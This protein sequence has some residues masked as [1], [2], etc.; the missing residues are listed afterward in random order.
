MFRKRFTALVVTLL[1]LTMSAVPLSAA[2]PQE[3]FQYSHELF[4]EIRGLVEGNYVLPID[5]SETY[6]GAVEGYI[7]GMGDPHTKFYTPEEYK[8]FTEGI[9]GIYEGVGLAIGKTD[10]YI[11]VISPVPN[12]PGEEAGIKTGDK[13]IEINGESMI[14]VSLDYAA[15]LLRG[16][17]GTKVLLKLDRD[18]EVFSV[19]LERRE[20]ET[21]SVEYELHGPI[22]YM[23]I[24]S[25]SEHLPEDFDE[26]MEYFTENEIEG[27]I[28]DVRNNPGG[29]LGS[30]HHIVSKFLDGTVMRMLFRNGL[31]LPLVTAEMEER[32][33]M[34]LVVLVN[35]GSASASEIFAGAVKDNERG[36]L[37]GTKTFGKGSV[38]SV[39]ELTN[40][41]FLKLT[42]SYY[43]TPG[44]DKID[45][46]GITPDIVVED[47]GEQ[48]EKAFEVM[49]N[50]IGTK[51]VFKLNESTAYWAGLDIELPTAPIKTDG[52]Y[53]LPLR[54]VFEYIGCGIEWV[55]EENA[56]R[57]SW[58]DREYMLY[59]EKGTLVIDEVEYSVDGVNMKNGN[60][61][62]SSKTLWDYMGIEMET[63]EDT[64]TII[65]RKQ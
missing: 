58:L 31:K 37:V 48:L 63:D 64:E 38:Q 28:I 35:G 5:E 56:V 49:R 6:K 25:F 17:A 15:S 29:V 1:I 41:G 55:S 8:E 23:E 13:I 43:F 59:P 40:G 10:E 3:E 45:G 60:I 65:L 24:S 32:Y 30:A 16:H 44:N 39:A 57:F 20:V 36:I 4:E 50:E 7:K 12:S 27:L 14:D 46:V 51:I 21:P 34:P 62:I 9:E 11:T 19:T 53:Y 33:D 47:P 52:E 22:G 26:A 42:T 2:E 54:T 18:G 61:L